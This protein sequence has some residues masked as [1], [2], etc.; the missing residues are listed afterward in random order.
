MAQSDSPIPPEP[1]TLAKDSLEQDIIDFDEE[2]IDQR[3]DPE[4]STLQSMCSLTPEDKKGRDDT[5]KP[6]PR[7]NLRYLSISDEALYYFIFTDPD[8]KQKHKLSRVDAWTMVDIAADLVAGVNV[9]YYVHNT[10][11]IYNIIA[12]IVNQ[13]PECPKAVQFPI[14]EPSGLVSHSATFSPGPFFFSL[15]N[16]AKHL[17][18]H[19]RVTTAP[20]DDRARPPPRKRDFPRRCEPQARRVDPVPTTSLK[21]TRALDRLLTSSSATGTFLAHSVIN[22][23]QTL[24]QDLQ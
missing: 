4:V 23:G 15:C 2:I 12:R 14:I 16:H 9:G 20:V 10:P 11:P 21:D 19:K 7:P 24:E 13:E 22:Y 17:K 8:S 3:F 5:T 6:V 1:D 18:F